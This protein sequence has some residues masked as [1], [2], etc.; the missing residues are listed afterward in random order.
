MIIKCIPVGPLATNCYIFGCSETLEASIIDPGLTR[1]EQAGLLRN[2]AAS[3]LKAKYIINTHGHPDH[4]SLNAE[5]KEA[6][7]AEILIHEWDAHLLEKPWNIIAEY[8]EIEP[9]KPD[10]LLRDQD[11]IMIGRLE[12]QV[13]HTPGHT[14]GSI[15]LHCREGNVVF[16]GDTLFYGSVGRTDLPGGSPRDL[17]S[18]L[19]NRLMRLPDNTVVYPGHGPKTTIGR[20]RRLNPFL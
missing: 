20:E 1:P 10:R 5:L 16:T 7:G 2:L 9:V 13:I 4:V 12:L 3:N 18:S 8:G 6:T 19:K 14:R 11:I 15:S 17:E